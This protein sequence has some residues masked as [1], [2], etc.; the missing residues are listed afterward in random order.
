MPGAFAPRNG[1]GERPLCVSSVVCQQR[2][3]VLFHEHD[4]CPALDREFF[5][6][7]GG[8]QERHVGLARRR[9]ALV[10]VPKPTAT[11]TIVPLDVDQARTS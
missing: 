4:P 5:S 1:P 6:A 8:M 2:R 11:R 7:R 10:Q 3:D 9:L